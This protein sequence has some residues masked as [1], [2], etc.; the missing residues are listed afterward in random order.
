MGCRDQVSNFQTMVYDPE[1][2]K[3]GCQWGLYMYKCLDLHIL[4]EA[5]AWSVNQGGHWNV[6]FDQEAKRYEAVEGEG[7]PG[8]FVQV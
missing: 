2:G 6:S 3:W 5:L 4:K 1:T 8:V 7:S